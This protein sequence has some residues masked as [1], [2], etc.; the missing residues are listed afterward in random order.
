MSVYE[1][2]KECTVQK[3]FLPSGVY[4][5]FDKI[6]AQ[7]NVVVTDEAPEILHHHVEVLKG[8]ELTHEQLPNKFQDHCPPG[9]QAYSAHLVDPDKVTE[10]DPHAANA[11]AT[12]FGSCYIILCFHI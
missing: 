4:E 9:F 6:E 1:H 2:N 12:H 7:D 8:F 3:S 10:T 11:N 5:A